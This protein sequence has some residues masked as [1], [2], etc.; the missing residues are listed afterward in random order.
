MNEEFKLVP[1]EDS[2]IVQIENCEI[3][4]SPKHI[5]IEL[6]NDDVDYLLMEKN[7]LVFLGICS[8]SD[9]E[10]I[11]CAVNVDLKNLPENVWLHRSNVWVNTVRNC[12]NCDS[13]VRLSENKSL[14]ID[15][16]CGKYIIL[17][18]NISVDDMIELM[19]KS[20]FEYFPCIM[21]NHT[22]GEIIDED[23]RINGKPY[24]QT[25]GEMVNVYYN[26]AGVLKDANGDFVQLYES[27]YEDCEWRDFT[28]EE[29]DKIASAIANELKNN[30]K[31]FLSMED[32]ERSVKSSSNNERRKYRCMVD[33]MGRPHSVT[34]RRDNFMLT[35]YIDEDTDEIS[36][37]FSFINTDKII[38]NLFSDGDDPLPWIKNLFFKMKEL[39]EKGEI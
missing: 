30:N 35:Q 16:I 13:R 38:A 15:N 10:K 12:Y 27:Y 36:Y 20:G 6:S 39:E 14:C 26:M 22:V 5:S 28:D 18:D 33:L 9:G 24:V 19:I 29:N 32:N 34:I 37:V 11:R 17:A 7:E 21:C 25:V 3:C 31:S 23:S 2:N 1:I 4:T 8:T